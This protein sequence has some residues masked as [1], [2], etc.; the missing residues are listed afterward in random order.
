MNDQPTADVGSAQASAPEVGVAVPAELSRVFP[1]AEPERKRPG[2]ISD[3]L[4]TRQLDY[5]R[6]VISFL[7]RRQVFPAKAPEVL[8]G[9]AALGTLHYS[10]NGRAASVEE[11]Q[12]LYAVSQEFV[13]QLPSEMVA[14]FSIWRQRKFFGFFPVIFSLIGFLALVG[15]YLNKAYAEPNSELYWFVTLISVLSWTCALGGLGTSAFFGT[16][17]L[18]Q[19]ASVSHNDQAKLKEITD[20]NY[21]RTRLMIGILFASVLG[22]PFGYSSLNR[23]SSSLYSDVIWDDNLLTTIMHIMAPFLLGFSTTLVLSI[24]DRIIEGIR[25]ILG[26]GQTVQAAAAPVTVVTVAGGPATP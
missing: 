10:P 17:L 5:T 6:D 14:T 2:K 15:T 18:A 20:N 26:V 7:V 19:L 13:S 11:W 21:L 24:L 4:F 16:S 22:L 8:A 9:L 12:N 25:T 1:P 3:R 23:A